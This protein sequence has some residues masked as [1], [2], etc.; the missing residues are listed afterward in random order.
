MLVIIIVKIILD[1][2]AISLNFFIYIS[3]HAYL[4][5]NLNTCIIFVMNYYYNN[6]LV[7]YKSIQCL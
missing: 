2:A 3:I 6:E 7:Y 5:M 4:K 1:N